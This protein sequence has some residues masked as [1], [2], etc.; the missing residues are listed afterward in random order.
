MSAAGV[1]V[2]G[3]LGLAAVRRLGWEASA[4]GGLTLGADPVAYAIALAS[5]NSPPTLD[6]FTVRKET[7][8]HGTGQLIEGCFTKGARVVVVEDVFTT[9]SSALRAVEAVRSAGGTVVG[10]LGVV[11]RE[12]GGVTAIRKAGLPVEALVSIRDLGVEPG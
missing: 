1:H 7:K 10:V 12:E 2:I 4:V 5:R 3:E 6:A 9:G 8:A 11:D